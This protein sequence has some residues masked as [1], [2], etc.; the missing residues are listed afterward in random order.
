M[1]CVLLIGP[2]NAS[3]LTTMLRQVTRFLANHP[4]CKA[5]H[6]NFIVPNPPMYASAI[7]AAEKVGAKGLAARTMP[8]LF[9][10]FETGLVK[11]GLDYLDQ[12]FGYYSIQS[13]KPASLG[14]GMHDSPV[15][16]LRCVCQEREAL[17]CS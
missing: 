9:S 11:R 2:S 8:W 15:A 12:G 3:A 10:D 1:L 5:Y 17:S 7:I 14:Y 13:T 6:T 16:V 4:G